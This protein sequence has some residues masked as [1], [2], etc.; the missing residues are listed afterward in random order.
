MLIK[1]LNILRH[2]VSSM[3]LAILDSRKRPIQTL[4]LQQLV[5]VAYVLRFGLCNCQI[6]RLRADHGLRRV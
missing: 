1:W 6:E 3:N 5:E 2:L 4:V